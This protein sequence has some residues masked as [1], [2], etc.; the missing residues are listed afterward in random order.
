MR[1]HRLRQKE[2]ALEVDIL[3]AI[4]VAWLDVEEFDRLGNAGVVDQN[5]DLTEG[6]D[7][8]LDGFGA[9]ALVGDVAGDSDVRPVAG[10][11]ETLGSGVRR[12]PVNIKDG[13]AGAFFR[14]P[15]G[16]CET[17]ASRRGR[18]CNDCRFA[19]KQHFVPPWYAFLGATVGSR[20]S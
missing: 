6:A 16:C 4:P 3:D 13:N 10:L 15:P 20:S 8:G 14:K 2:N 9:G 17:D 19:A 18:T 7:N 12:G 11:F 5:V 1:N